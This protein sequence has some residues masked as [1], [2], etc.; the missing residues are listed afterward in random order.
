MRT[1]LATIAA[2]ALCACATGPT[3]YQAANSSGGL[4]Y[5]SQPIENDRVRISYTA[6]QPDEAESFALRRAAE[7]AAERGAPF[8]EV[9]RQD[10]FADGGAV[11]GGGSGVNVGV[12]GGTTIGG[13]RGFGRSSGVGVG[14]GVD[15]GRVFGGGG[16][17]RL[18]TSTLDI[19]LRQA[20]PEGEAGAVNTYSTREV[21][22]QF[23]IQTET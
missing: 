17:D 10:T 11:R 8:F 6:R 4:G 12:G 1:A 16:G 21:L 15:L 14:V 20:R 3:P 5:S 13:R 19:R 2:L 22:E 9:L 23:S 7:V 18:A